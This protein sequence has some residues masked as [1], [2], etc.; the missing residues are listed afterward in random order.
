MPLKETPGRSQV[1]L[2]PTGGGLGTA[3]P[4]GAHKADA[5]SRMAEGFMAGET[6]VTAAAADISPTV[7]AGVKERSTRWIAALTAAPDGFTLA[8]IN[9]RQRVAISLLQ[10]VLSRVSPNE[11]GRRFSSEE[12]IR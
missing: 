1:S 10:Q 11:I 8:D 4:W 5:A 7:I 3:R 9:H 6:T 12:A 2:T